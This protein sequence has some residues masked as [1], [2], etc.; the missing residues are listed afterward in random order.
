MDRTLTKPSVEAKSFPLIEA[1]VAIATIG[2]L[3]T[4]ALQKFLAH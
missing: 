1:M 4:I 2:I 3:V